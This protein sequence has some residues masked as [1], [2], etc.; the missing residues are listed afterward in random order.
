MRAC[1]SRPQRAMYM[2]DTKKTSF[3]IPQTKS[4]SPVDVDA[5]PGRYSMLV[6]AV[7]AFRCR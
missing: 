5:C 2:S 6:Y 3:S 1:R 4:R 7:G